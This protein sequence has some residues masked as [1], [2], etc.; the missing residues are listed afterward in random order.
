MFTIF[1]K[2]Y[3]LLTFMG[4]GPKGNTIIQEATVCCMKM[5]EVVIEGARKWARQKAKEAGVDVEG[6]CLVNSLELEGVS[7]SQKGGEK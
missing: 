7:E 6:M 5:T 2:R 1:R 4:F 3:F